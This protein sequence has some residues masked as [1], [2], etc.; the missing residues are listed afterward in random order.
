LVESLGRFEKLA[1]VWINACLT[2][3]ASGKAGSVR[4][5]KTNTAQRK[6]IDRGTGRW[7]QPG[8]RN[9]IFKN[10]GNENGRGL[11]GHA[12]MPNENNRVKIIS[13]D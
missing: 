6:K 7:G 10:C 4:F 11:N 3:A 2:A 5:G 13:S 8:Q 12:P 1:Q 9:G